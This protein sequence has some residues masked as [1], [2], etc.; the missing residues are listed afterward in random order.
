MKL[1]MNFY[2]KKLADAGW[3][4]M[5]SQLDLEMPAPKERRRPLVFW[6][7]LL[8]GCSLISGWAGWYLA[9]YHFAQNQNRMLFEKNTLNVYDG[10]HQH[11]HERKQNVLAQ[12]KNLVSG[13]TT[14][15]NCMLP[16][17]IVADDVEVSDV[18]A[19]APVSSSRMQGGPK[20]APYLSNPILEPIFSDTLPIPSKEAD[21]G[22]KIIDRLLPAHPVRHLVFGPSMGIFTERFQRMN[23]ASI[24]A[25]VDFRPSNRWGI[26]SGIY[27][28]Y[29]KPS[30][31]T[32]PVASLSAVNYAKATGSD[33]LLDD[34]GQLLDPATGQSTPATKVY[35]PLERLDRLEMPVLGYV[36]FFHRFR[37]FFGPTISYTHRVEA[38]KVYALNEVIYRTKD[39]SDDRAVNNLAKNEV[40]RWQLGLQSGFG[41]RLGDRFELDLFYRL[42]S[43]RTYNRVFYKYNGAFLEYAP[44]GSGQINNSSVFALN[45]TLF[46]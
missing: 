3:E 4:S 18:V 9:S 41:V 34:K 20:P 24:G 12:T 14:S 2:D 38:H 29:L 30:P 31:S 32:R 25:L 10:T 5:R 37:Y 13:S 46:F 15:T 11:Q 26:V 8:T 27:Y 42:N 35:V 19:E 22:N 7:I 44:Q 16:A 45:G 6:L 39:R 21:P 43:I 17:L 36:Q 33:Y 40:H 1:K 23:G 28:S